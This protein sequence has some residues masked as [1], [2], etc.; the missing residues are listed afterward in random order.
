MA[1]YFFLRTMDWAAPKPSSAVAV[2]NKL[3]I[4]NVSITQ[5]DSGGSRGWDCVGALAGSACVPEKMR[6]AASDQCAQ[7]AAGLYPM[8]WCAY[9]NKGQGFGVSYGNKGQGFVVS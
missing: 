4:L 3:R 9:G 6:G 8:C 7:S 5:L 2:F 1:A